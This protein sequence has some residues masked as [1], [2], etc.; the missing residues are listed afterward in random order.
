[1]TIS[2]WKWG[3]LFIITYRSSSAG[4]A[5]SSHTLQSQYIPQMMLVKNLWSNT[6]KLSVKS[7]PRKVFIFT[8]PVFLCVFRCFLL[9][10]FPVCK[11]YIQTL[12]LWTF[13]LVTI[14]KQL[15]AAYCIFQ[16]NTKISPRHKLLNKFESGVILKSRYNNRYLVSCKHTFF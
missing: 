14:M 1:M 15:Q 12:Y 3:K 16:S 7:N 10:T 2:V 9:W 5:F 11:N 8:I 6:D 4:G 13:I